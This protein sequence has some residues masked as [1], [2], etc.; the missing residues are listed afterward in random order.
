MRDVPINSKGL[1][2]LHGPLQGEYTLS[3]AIFKSVGDVTIGL[4]LK[5]TYREILKRSDVPQCLKE[6]EED[7]VKADAKKERRKRQN[8]S[9]YCGTYSERRG[10]GR[11]SAIRLKTSHKA[12]I[13]WR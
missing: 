13:E 2:I 4:I 12:C 11:K 8:T 3:F 5:T 7:S 1:N 6:R 9:I 10:T